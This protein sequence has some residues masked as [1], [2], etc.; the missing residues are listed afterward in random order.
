MLGRGRRILNFLEN[1]YIRT[2]MG[3][4][5][6]AWIECSDSDTESDDDT[7]DSEEGWHEV[8][9]YDTVQDDNGPEQGKETR[10]M[11]AII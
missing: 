7:T 11:R 3:E 2:S 1:L 6:S 5:M 8:K 10:Q 4:D 9:D